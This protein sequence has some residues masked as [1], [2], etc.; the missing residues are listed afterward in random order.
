MLGQRGGRS[1][2][3]ERGLR[4]SRRWGHGE[5]THRQLDKAWL[6]GRGRQTAAAEGRRENEE[7]LR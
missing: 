2:G 1:A 3:H 7:R 6:S 4:G 5:L